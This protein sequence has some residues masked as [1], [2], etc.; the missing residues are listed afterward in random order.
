MFLGVYLVSAQLMAS[1]R[2]GDKPLVEPMMTKLYD[3]HDDVIKWKHFPC[4]WPFVRG[5]HRSPGNSPLEGQWPRALM[6]YFRSAPAET[7]K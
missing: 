6:F 4:Y 2:T 3:T 1:R 5:I 7:V